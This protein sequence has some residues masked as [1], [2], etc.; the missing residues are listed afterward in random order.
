ML[1]KNA[2]SELRKRFKNEVSE[3]IYEDTYMF[4]K[5]LK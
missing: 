1:K 5:F 2:I 3:E 4:Y